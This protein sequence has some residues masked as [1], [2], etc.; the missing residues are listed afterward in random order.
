MYIVQYRNGKKAT[1]ASPLKSLSNVAKQPLQ[2]LS[3]PSVLHV[4]KDT[5]PRQL[6]D[7]PLQVLLEPACMFRR[8]VRY[9]LAAELP[10]DSRGQG[11]GGSSLAVAEPV[12]VGLGCMERVK[13]SA[14]SASA[15][16]S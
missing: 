12:L 5:R 6:R 1:T 9:Q 3:R 2:I 11:S 4:Q 13:A 14:A 15:V 16:P 7:R 8:P 10:S